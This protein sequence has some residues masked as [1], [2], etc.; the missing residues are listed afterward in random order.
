MMEGLSRES[1]L[2]LYQTDRNLS[3]EEINTIQKDLEVFCTEWTAHN[4]QLK[5]GY[6]II[7]RRIIALAVDESMNDA[8]GCSIDKSVNRL[9]ELGTA[10]NIDFF[11]RMQMLFKTENQIKSIDFNEVAEKYENQTV[12]DETLIYNMNISKLGELKTEFL[13]PLKSHWLYQKI[14]K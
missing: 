3:E 8:S 11:G 7:D 13:I 9:K 14:K 2:W 6:E 5:A 10:L 1:K 4:K 12:S